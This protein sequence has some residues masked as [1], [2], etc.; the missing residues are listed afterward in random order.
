MTS[1][2]DDRIWTSFDATLEDLQRPHLFLR[3]IENTLTVAQSLRQNY[4]HSTAQF[5]SHLRRSL[6]RADPIIRIGHADDC[7]WPDLH[8]EVVTFIDGGVGQAQIASRIP[9]LLRVGSYAVK[10]GERNLHERE[11]FGYYPILLGELEGGSK[12]RKDFVDIVRIT[13]ELL[14]GL[15]ALDRTPDLRALLFH[16]PLVYLVSAYAGHAPFTEADIDLFLRQYALDAGHGRRLKERFLTEARLDIYPEI[17]HERVDYAAERRLFEP[18]SWMSFLYR[19]LVDEASRR[20]PVPIVAGVVERGGALRDFSKDVLLKRIFRNLR[21]HNKSDYFNRMFG[22]DDLVG[23][24]MLLER[25]GYT[26][27]LLLAMLLRP[28]EYSEPWEMERKYN[29]LRSGETRLPAEETTLRVDWSPLAPGRSISFPRVVGTYLQVSDTT[30]PLRIE[31]FPDLGASQTRDAARRV[32]RY[33]SLLPGYGFPVGLDIADKYAHV[34]AW[35]TD[36]YGKMIRY[37][38]SANLQR[39]E[40]TDEALRRIIVQALYLTNRDWLFRPDV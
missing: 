5:V 4:F 10:T 39:G 11:Q 16:G 17:L 37:H 7:A 23:P 12:D 28:G 15:S 32:F 2:G 6:D 20:R 30:E 9:L 34:P 24:D 22:R 3:L 25:L 13:A 33:A 29:G 1:A 31:V 36:A 18:L 26:D 35:M 27:A 38:L 19:M 21:D 40:I 8:G 14:G